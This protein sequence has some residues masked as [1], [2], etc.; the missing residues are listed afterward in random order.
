MLIGSSLSQIHTYHTHA[1]FYT[2]DVRDMGEFSSRGV[3]SLIMH[4][5]ACQ[6]VIND[7][8]LSYLFELLDHMHNRYLYFSFL[9]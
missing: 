7:V 3:R 8:A 5:I 2:Q 6:Q 1:V 9:N 4:Y